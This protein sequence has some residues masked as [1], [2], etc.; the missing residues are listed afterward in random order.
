MDGKK[1]GDGKH[2]HNILHGAGGRVRQAERE[3][4]GGL[5]EQQRERGRWREV[6]LG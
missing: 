6:I 3:G 2:S 5:E 4:G 1:G